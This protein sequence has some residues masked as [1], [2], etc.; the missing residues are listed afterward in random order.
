MKITSFFLIASL[1]LLAAPT[2]AETN[3]TA[4]GPRGGSSVGT[5]SCSYAGGSTTCQSQSTYTNPKGKVFQRAATG[6][7]NATGGQRIIT[8]TG[9]DGR[10][11]TTTR[12]WTR[13]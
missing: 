10:V 3:W 13:N 2:M 9:P 5:T 6:S 11:A 4:T 12:N 1:G 8:T 7:G